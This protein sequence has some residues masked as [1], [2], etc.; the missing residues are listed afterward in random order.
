MCL[1]PDPKIQL[2]VFLHTGHTRTDLLK[3]MKFSV[4]FFFRDQRG[5][6][7]IHRYERPEIMTDLIYHTGHNIIFLIGTFF[8]QIRIHL[9]SCTEA[10][11]LIQIQ[12]S[13][14]FV[15][16][17]YLCGL[18]SIWQKQILFQSPVQKSTHFSDGYDTQSCCLSECQL[19]LLHRRDRAV[20]GILV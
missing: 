1:L 20:I 11:T 10:F 2:T 17:F 7:V 19:R 4:Q 15:A 8:L 5:I 12:G 18:L 13:D 14:H 16:C 6:L 3:H 9:H